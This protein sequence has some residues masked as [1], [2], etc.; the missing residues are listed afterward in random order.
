MKRFYLAGLS[1]AWLLLLNACEM[2]G[3]FE[4]FHGQSPGPVLPEG[5]PETSDPSRHGPQMAQIMRPDGSCFWIDTLEV[6]VAEY[7]EFIGSDD[8]PVQEGVCAWN[9][10]KPGASAPA[11]SS[12]GLEPATEC[13]ETA[14]EIAAALD[15]R[16]TRNL[17][18][19][20]VDWCDA[21]AFCVWAGKDLCRDDGDRQTRGAASDWF[22][23][24][25][26]GEDHTYGCGDECNA[27]ACNG[28]SAKNE[29]LESV[30]SLPGCTTGG[31]VADLSGN[32]AEWTNWCSPNSESG[33]C[34]V[35][36]GSFASSDSGVECAS[37]AR[38]PRTSAQATIGFRCCANPIDD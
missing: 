1:G 30:G 28:A 24:C 33:S 9:S 25:S 7:L 34:L 27:T 32:A 29:R 12:P 4:D 16:A 13:V 17:P 11:D 21:L 6:S 8:Q 14:S 18:M 37:A 26:E 36:G 31:K 15:D 35:R 10:G 23:A 19:T 5:C 3:G 20:C 38:A 22:Q 2:I